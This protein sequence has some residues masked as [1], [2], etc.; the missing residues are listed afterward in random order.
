MTSELLKQAL[1]Y[2]LRTY[3]LKR[4]SMTLLAFAKFTC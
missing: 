4:E 1:Y 3:L 2:G